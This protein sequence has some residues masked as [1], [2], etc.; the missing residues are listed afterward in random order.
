MV[1][2]LVSSGFRIIV[3]TLRGFGAIT[4]VDK[5]VIRSG[6]QGALGADLIALI[7]VL[8]LEPVV[9]AGYL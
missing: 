8:Q 2:V 5:T 9:A 4:C 7:E 6:R 3:P 1:P